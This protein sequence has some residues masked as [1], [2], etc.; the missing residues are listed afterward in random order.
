MLPGIL[1]PAMMEV[2]KRVTMAMATII[3]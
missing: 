1:N 2:R 3:W